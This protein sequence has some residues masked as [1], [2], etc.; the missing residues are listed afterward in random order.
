MQ[1]SIIKA[2]D[3]IEQLASSWLYL[4]QC[5]MPSENSNS[6]AQL[7]KHIRAK[8]KSHLM[9]LCVHDGQPEQ[10]L[11]ALCVIE[12]HRHWMSHRK[13]WVNWVAQKGLDST[14]LVSDEQRF[15]ALDTMLHKQPTNHSAQVIHLRQL[16]PRHPT[17]YALQAICKTQNFHTRSS[18]NTYDTL[19]DIKIRLQA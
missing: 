10:N 13:T 8:P 17:V 14:L 9:V 3:A 5:S 2:Q 6:H 19:C 11:H 12:A 4:Q 15:S 16:N 18:H 1:L 7:L